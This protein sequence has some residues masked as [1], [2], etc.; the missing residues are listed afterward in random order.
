MVIF[1]SYVSL[2]EGIITIIRNPSCCDDHTPPCFFG[3]SLGQSNLNIP[4]KQVM[5]FLNSEYFRHHL[6]ILHGYFEAQICTIVGQH[7]QDE[8]SGLKIVLKS[9]AKGFHLS[10]N[11]L[12]HWRLK[13]A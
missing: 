5:F 3:Q 10:W 9:G 6:A 4:W 11:G 7:R 2:P 8:S 13:M 1:R 12:A